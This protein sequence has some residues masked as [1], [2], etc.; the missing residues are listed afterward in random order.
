MTCGECKDQFS[1]CLDGGLPTK[2]RHEIDEHLAICE[3]C[4][5]SLRSMRSL[6]LQLQNLPSTQLPPAFR[7]GMRRALIAADQRWSWWRNGIKRV[8]KAPPMAVG[9]IAGV[10]TAL[11]V[12]YVI[13][14][15]P[16]SGMTPW[17]TQSEAQK[18][19]SP[20]VNYVLDRIPV[21]GYPLEGTPPDT[22][23][24][25]ATRNSRAARQVSAEF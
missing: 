17:M 24:K 15:P 25:R 8:S 1:N 6:K 2:E 4:Q 20:S 10:F 13:I 22:S 16:P 23:V 14:A 9:G 19:E 3:E 18:S 7:F 21:K 11:L 5:G 12:S